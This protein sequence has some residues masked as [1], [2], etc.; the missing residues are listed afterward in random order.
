MIALSKPTLYARLGSKEEIYLRVLERE[1]SLLKSSLFLA[2]DRAS[3]EPVDHVAQLIDHYIRRP[4][5][6]PPGSA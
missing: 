3:R 4:C 5:S 2:Y 1:A 6:P